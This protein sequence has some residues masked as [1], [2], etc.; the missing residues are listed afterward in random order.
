MT[1]AVTHLAPLI[2]DLAIILV[3]AGIVS[4]IFHKIHQPV[5]IGYIIAGIIVGPYTP[6]FPLVTDIRGIQLWAELGVIFLMFSLGLE[7]SFRKMARVGISAGLTALIE[8]LF[9]LALGFGVGKLFGYSVMDCLFLGA[10]LSIS[11]TTIII[12]ALDDLKLKTRRFAELIFAVLVVEDVLAVLILVTLTTIAISGSLSSLVVLIT[13][14][15]LILV[16]GGWFIAGYFVIPRFM[17]YV[18]RVGTSEI[19]T[20]ISLGLCLMLVVFAANMHYSVALGAFIMGSILAESSES[21]RILERIQPLRDLFA[22]IFFVSIGMLLNPKVLWQNL[23]AVVVISIVTVLGKLVSST[24]GALVSGQSLRTSV[25]VGFGLAQIGEFSF[26]IATLGATLKVTSDVLYPVGVAVSIIT[27]FTTPY[28]IRYSGRF[29]DTIE[30]HLPVRL[31]FLLS[32]Y[33]IWMEE[34][35]E[36]DVKRKLFYQLAFRWF[37]NGLIVS[38][39]FISSS[40]VLEPFLEDKISNEVLAAALCWFLT[41]IVSFPFIWGLFSAFKHFQI[42]DEEQ[43][44]EISLPGKS[45]LFVSRIVSVI[46]LAV[47]SLVYFDVE[48]VVLITGALVIGLFWLFYQKIGASYRWFE[49]QFL[50]SFE[51]KARKTKKTGQQIEAFRGLSPWDSQLSRMK[52]HPN[53]KF[54]LKLL[55]ESG[56]RSKFGVSV[57]AIQ[58]GNQVIVAPEPNQ[59]IFPQDELLILGT[60]DQIESVRPSIE[61]DKEVQNSDEKGDLSLEQYDLRHFRILEGS[62][63][64]NT[65]I[66]ASGIRE[67]YSAIVVGME[68]AGTR[69]INPSPDLKLKADDTLWI[70]G[71]IDQ[72][73]LLGARFQKLKPEA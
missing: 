20:L 70:V 12:K 21:R 18:G 24:F 51:P 68:R 52:V 71:H 73:N 44:K 66:R 57:I 46:W 15:K 50:S 47:L 48:Y 27:T 37:L 64:V 31:K 54:Q 69:S 8:V 16:V 23:G 43:G 26:I 38:I 22:A 67:N 60:E 41:V 56:L 42:L 40:G 72:L 35:R 6:P 17:K 19:V 2:H 3:I 30:S 1:D 10:M 13:I 28:L 33:L 55:K 29:A 39:L 61:N 36:D 59:W 5:V 9:M 11:S 63:W 49:K 7:L 14:G 53:S 32:R 4:L 62:Y 58:R 65:T 45:I 34:K 25:Q